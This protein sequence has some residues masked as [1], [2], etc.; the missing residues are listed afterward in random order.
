MAFTA[1]ERTRI[2]RTPY[3]ARQLRKFIAAKGESGVGWDEIERLFHDIPRKKLYGNLRGLVNA[4]HIRYDSGVYVPV[5]DGRLPYG[6]QADNVWQA[7][8]I[9]RTFTVEKLAQTSDATIKHANQLCWQWQR[10]G[11]LVVIGRDGHQT[12]F[13]LVKDSP[14]RPQG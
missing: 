1:D 10:S 11:H 12:I 14:A 4:G 2:F 7:A 9:L 13:R 6:S 8:R 5:D 3:P